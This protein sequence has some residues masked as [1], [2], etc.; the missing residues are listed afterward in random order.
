MDLTY[1]IRPSQSV[2]LLQLTTLLGS[3]LL[4]VLRAGAGHR[5]RPGAATL[6]PSSRPVSLL[7]SIISLAKDAKNL[8]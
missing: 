2:R 3:D 7:R 6:A 5:V 8:C 1:G 4:Q